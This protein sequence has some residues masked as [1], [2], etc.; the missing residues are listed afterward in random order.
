MALPKS[1]T[2]FQIKDKL[3]ETGL[4]GK[5]FEFLTD[6]TREQLQSLFEAGEMLEPY[7]RSRLN[8]MEGK[9]LATLFFRAEIGRAS[10]RERV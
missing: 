3:A 5:N 10:C 6:Y 4:R 8:L 9:V 2:P 7:W 1:F